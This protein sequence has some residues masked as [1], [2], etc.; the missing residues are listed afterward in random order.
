V[1]VT[2]SL[3]CGLAPPPDKI[4]IFV[5]PIDFVINTGPPARAD[6]QGAFHVGNA[7][8]GRQAISSVNL[9]NFY[10]KGNAL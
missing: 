3:A 1:E 2:V 6:R 5:Q 9:G 4:A 10:I 7:A 8:L